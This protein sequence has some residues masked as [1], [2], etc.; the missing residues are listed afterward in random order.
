MPLYIKET[1]RFRWSAHDAGFVRNKY[2]HLGGVYN[3]RW[4]SEITKIDVLR[5]YGCC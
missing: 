4:P 3:V 1:E 2:H 5:K